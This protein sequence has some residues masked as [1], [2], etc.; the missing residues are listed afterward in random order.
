MSYKSVRHNHSFSGL[1]T[2][3]DVGPGYQ[4]L[5]VGLAMGRKD[6]RQ[7]RLTAAWSDAYSTGTRRLN[8]ASGGGRAH[9]RATASSSY[10]TS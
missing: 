2:Y 8:M 3:I 5:S 9:S 7:Y 10:R 4:T 1:A 6:D